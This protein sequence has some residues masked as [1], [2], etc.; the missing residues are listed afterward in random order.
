MVDM[1]RGSW[2]QKGL[3]AKGA[4]SEGEVEDRLV[5]NKRKYMCEERNQPYWKA[6]A[7]ELLE[8]ILERRKEI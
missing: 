5:A 7:S 1:C 8:P 6:D 4:K 3:G 2:I